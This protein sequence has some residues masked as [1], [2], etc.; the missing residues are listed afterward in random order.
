MKQMEMT[1]CDFVWPVFIRLHIWNHLILR[2]ITFCFIQRSQRMKGGKMKYKEC[3]D[4]RGSVEIIRG[5]PEAAGDLAPVSAV[6][7]GVELLKNPTLSWLT[8]EQEGNKK[9]TREPPTKP[10][11]KGWE[12]GKIVKVVKGKAFHTGVEGTQGFG[13]VRVE[14]SQEGWQRKERR[15]ESTEAAWRR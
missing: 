6:K 1:S 2:T 4:F 14:S 5:R 13:G 11:K 7:L 15:R 9:K 12:L 3:E 8:F 10:E